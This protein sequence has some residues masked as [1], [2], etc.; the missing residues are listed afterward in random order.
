MDNQTKHHS[1][2]SKLLIFIL[3]GFLLPALFISIYFLV[4]MNALSN[5]AQNI[6][7][8]NLKAFE[9]ELEKQIQYPVQLLKSSIESL[10]NEKAETIPEPVL[11][12]RIKAKI[13]MEHYSDNGYFFLIKYDG[14]RLVAPDDRAQEGKNAWE[15]TDPNGVKIIQELIKKAQNG[16]GFVSYIWNN[17]ATNHPEPKKSYVVP[18]KL[19]GLEAALG[20]GIYLTIIQKTGNEIA[21][22]INIGQKNDISTSLL[23]VVGFLVIVL[24]M[25]Y[26]YI[27][28]TI[29]RSIIAVVDNIKQIAEGDLTSEISIKNTDEIGRM[30]TELEKMKRKFS[31]LIANV[32]N[33]SEQV[34]N[35]SR[36]IAV[37]NQN[38]SQRTQEQASTLEEISATMEEI[39]STVNQSAQ[40]S[41]EADQI[42]LSTLKTVKMGEHA[43]QETNEAMREISSSSKQIV[44]I[45]KVVNDIAFQ[46]NLLALNAAIE[47][48]RAGEQGR[49]F[50][51]VAAEVRNLAGRTAESSKQIEQLISESVARVE[52]GDHL[53]Q[54]S[55]E[56]LQQIV[57][58][59]KR[60]SDAISEVASAS[61]EEAAALNQIQSSI[62]QLNQVTQQNAAMVEEIVASSHF[63]NTEAKNLYQMVNQFKIK[64]GNGNK[65]SPPNNRIFSNVDLKPSSE[66]HSAPLKDD[67]DFSGDEWEKF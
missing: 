63:L 46:T 20:T 15:L 26:W 4:R 35:V 24:I 19:G 36:E 61:N 51:V 27:Q 34:E 2:K 49:G 59:T 45:I 7:K 14:T 33:A 10:Y 13:R 5:D 31:N 38:L 39:N 52:R 40:H 32:L 60:T 22:K 58:N 23:I 47:A 8:N 55:A 29:T 50:A 6:T 64:H 43:I 44:E 56:V 53:V 48:A 16:G 18:I 62:Q 30:V 3:A 25:S 65:T 21:E 41:R 37:G 9:T 66:K 57:E 12:E 54:Q 1:L 42:S 67:N 11:I 17:P 28:H